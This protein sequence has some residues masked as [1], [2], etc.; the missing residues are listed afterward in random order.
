MKTFYTSNYGR[1]GTDAKGV[2]ISHPRD[3]PATFQGNAA[4][5]L[6]PTEE[7]LNEYHDR[8]IGH[9]EYEQQYITLLQSRGLS[10]QSIVEQYEDGTIFLCYDYED[11][12]ASICHRYLLSGWLNESGLAQVSEIIAGG[13]VA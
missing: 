1:S 9:D 6:A 8:K 5:D 4:N 3:I 13:N 2:A 7:M 12:D 11:G 10:P